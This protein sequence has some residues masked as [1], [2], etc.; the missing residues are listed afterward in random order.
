MNRKSFPLSSLTIR[1]LVPLY[2]IHNTLLFT[3]SLLKPDIASIHVSID[4]SIQASI[5]APIDAPV[6]IPILDSFDIITYQE[7]DMMKNISCCF[8]TNSSETQQ[9][10]SPIINVCIYR[11]MDV[12]WFVSFDSFQFVYLYLFLN[13]FDIIWLPKINLFWFVCVIR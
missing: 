11:R 9:N 4:V 1:S 13:Q 8:M 12:L 6:L 3:T 10:G 7:I 5:H 2:A